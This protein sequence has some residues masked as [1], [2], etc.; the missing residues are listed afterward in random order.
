MS[1]IVTIR[2]EVRSATAVAAACTRLK[3]PGPRQGSFELFG[4]E[5]AGLGVEL[6]GW[7]Y[8]VVCQLETGKLKFDDFQGRWG[9]R[10]HLDQFLQAYAVERTKLAAR[11]QGLSVTEQTLEGGSIKVTVDAGAA[12]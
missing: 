6:P 11:Q 2:T 8:P 3:L 4:G 1:H 5:V 10:V 7:R 9:K 12:T